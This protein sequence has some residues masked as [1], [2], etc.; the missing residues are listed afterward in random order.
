M[1]CWKRN[2]SHTKDG[3]MTSLFNY[4]T[5][6]VTLKKDTRTLIVELNRPQN[7]NAINTE[8]IFELESLFSWCVAR[9]EIHS[10]LLTSTTELL[11]CGLD[12]EE[13]KSMAEEKFIKNMNKLQKLIYA[14]FFL[15]QT[16]VVD[17]KDGATGLG[18]ELALAADIRLARPGTKIAFN[19]L[20]LGFTPSCGG[21]G[22]LSTII[23]K[24]FAKS[25]I[26]SG[27]TIS[28]DALLMSGYIH[29]Y[30]NSADQIENV[31]GSIADQAPVARIQAK[32][33]FLEA[34]M[35]ELDKTLNFEQRFAA[36]VLATG[37]W[38]KA[39]HDEKNFISA[40][41]MG[42]ILNDDINQEARAN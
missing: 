29:E 19:H 22:F 32:R 37:D 15:P 25:W 5:F 21:I 27:T 3:T 7:Q 30:Y 4:N 6:N 9:V 8:M 14:M 35:P 2:R 24:S 31:L 16:I 11:S 42:Q 13:A 41:Q 12:K 40:Q 1:D 18:A 28:N 17:L 26:L 34:L 38:K 10:I 33:S 20:K 36:G 39:M 23:S